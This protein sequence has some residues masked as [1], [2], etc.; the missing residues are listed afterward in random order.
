MS[1]RHARDF[2]FVFFGQLFHNA[3][4][5]RICKKSL[6]LGWIRPNLSMCTNVK[7]KTI[8]RERTRKR[9]AIAEN[10]AL[11]LRYFGGESVILFAATQARINE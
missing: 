6:D 10:V 2:Y 11:I 4:P 8:G 3:S 9:Y 5:F 1:E 7:R